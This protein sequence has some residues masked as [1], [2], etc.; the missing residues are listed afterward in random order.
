MKEGK[1]KQSLFG[2]SVELNQNLKL[3]YRSD[4]G[5]IDISTSTEPTSFLISSSSTFLGHSEHL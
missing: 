5:I 4:T 2:G 3:K 1:S